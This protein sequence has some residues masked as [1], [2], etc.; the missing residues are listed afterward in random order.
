MTAVSRP[1]YAPQGAADA[2]IEAGAVALWGGRA[3]DRDGSLDLPH[4]RMHA[5]GDLAL[6]RGFQVRDLLRKAEATY[7]DLP[8]DEAK[9]VYQYPLDRA[10]L[11]ARKAGGYVY[12]LLAVYR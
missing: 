7:Y 9:V 8:E 6:L 5:T 3:I 10:H 4:D 11:V 1:M 2:A 12:L